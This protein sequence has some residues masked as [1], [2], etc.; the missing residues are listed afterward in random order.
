M[1]DNSRRTFV[2]KIS[3]V[4]AAGVLGA[5]SSGEA[6]EENEKSSKEVLYRL[7]PDWEKY[8]ETLK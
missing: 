2:K 5:T 6:A 3:V 8:Y 7:T 4:T 1:K